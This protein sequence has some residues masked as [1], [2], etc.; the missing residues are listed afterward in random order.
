[1]QTARYRVVPPVEVV[2]TPLPFEI[3]HCWSLISRRREKEEEG[4]EEEKKRENL[5]KEEEG[6]AFPIRCPRAISSPRAGRRNGVRRGESTSRGDQAMHFNE[7]PHGCSLKPRHQGV[8]EDE[9][10][11]SGDEDAQ[12][13]EEGLGD[14]CVP[15]PENALP[16][17]LKGALERFFDVKIV[18]AK[19]SNNCCCRAHWPQK[20]HRGSQAACVGRRALRK[21][22]PTDCARPASRLRLQIWLGYPRSVACVGRLA[23][24]AARGGPLFSA[25]GDRIAVHME[26][27]AR[28]SHRLTLA[29]LCV[30]CGGCMRDTW[31]LPA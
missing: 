24:A 29:L 5:E 16:F 14:H 3:D 30:T 6:A 7:V 23:Q 2:S 26:P 9:V 12:E 15:N 17:W 10:G 22:W 11:G 19:R 31:Q 21:G 18:D 4:E 28:G 27:S 8:G 25:Q 1:M 20:R 13:D